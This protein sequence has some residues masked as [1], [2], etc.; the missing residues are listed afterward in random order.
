MGDDFFVSPAVRPSEIGVGEILAA[1]G[2]SFL[3]C[4]FMERE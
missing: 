4:Y 1:F 3:P 2:E